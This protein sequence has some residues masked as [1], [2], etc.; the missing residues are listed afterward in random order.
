[1]ITDTESLTAAFLAALVEA[2]NLDYPVTVRPATSQETAPEDR[3][4][5]TTRIEALPNDVAG[6]T[7]W[8]GR[9]QVF[10]VSPADVEGITAAQHAA[11]ER[12]ITTCFAPANQGALAAVFT[13]S[14]TGIHC[15][16]FARTGWLPGRQDT[17][18]QPYLSVTL[19]LSF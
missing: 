2:A 4:I 9:L 6:S 5:I 8:I 16:S 18:W 17:D 11:L 19:C 7:L 12:L 1:M 3:H 15:P 14:G 10:V 13:A